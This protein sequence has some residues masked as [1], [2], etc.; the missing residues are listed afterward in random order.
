MVIPKGETMIRHW[1][2]RNPCGIIDDLRGAV[3]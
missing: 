1:L 3:A 2:G